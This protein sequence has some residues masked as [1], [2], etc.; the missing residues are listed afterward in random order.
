M[1]NMRQTMTGYDATALDLMLWIVAHTLPPT[2]H[3]WSDADQPCPILP[4]AE[5]PGP[6]AGKAVAPCRIVDQDLLEK[7][8]IGEPFGERVDRP[9]PPAIWN[10]SAPAPFIIRSQPKDFGK[11]TLIVRPT[12]PPARAPRNSN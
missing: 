7:T 12:G 3:S 8:A 11:Q 4:P 10:F 6:S 1:R 9:I 5:T 2:G